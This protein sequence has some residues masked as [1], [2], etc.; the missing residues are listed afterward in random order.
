[1]IDISL[2]MRTDGGGRLVLDLGLRFRLIFLSFAAVVAFAMVVA[3]TINVVPLLLFLILLVGAAYEERWVFDP[4]SRTLCSR[5][6][7]LV[8]ART[9]RW[10][11]SEFR[12]VE[13]TSY[14]IGSVPGKDREDS[15]E[16][17]Y[18]RARNKL[19][20]RRILRYGLRTS[21]E[22]VVQIE[23]RRVRD[24]QHD[25]V[26]PEMIAKILK[27]PIERVDQ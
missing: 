18:D 7:L 24:L 14:R 17:S 22:E 10:T 27:I 19:R 3:S 12:A 9:R 6:G 26:I 20:Q 2:R 21:D 1:M 25:R 4:G 23:I 11:F 13:Y 15:D 16:T 8:L 5:H